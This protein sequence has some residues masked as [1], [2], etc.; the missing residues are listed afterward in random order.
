MLGMRQSAWTRPLE[1]AVH[2]SS[3]DETLC[4]LSK[5]LRPSHGR[6]RCRVRPSSPQVQYSGLTPLGTSLNT[7]VIQPFLAAGVHGHNLA[8][9]IL[10]RLRVLQN[11]LVPVWR[12]DKYSMTI[13][14][15]LLCSDSFKPG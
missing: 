4:H 5:S 12:P 13:L 14:V 2:S 11:I 7:K 10:V 6:R 9:P 3:P 8:K 15:K 1:P